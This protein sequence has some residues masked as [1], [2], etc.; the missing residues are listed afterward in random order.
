MFDT[1][2][3]SDCGFGHEIITYLY[4]E[5]GSAERK[6]FEDHLDTCVH[7]PGELAAFASVSTAIG[8]WKSGKFD[9]LSTPQFV[10]PKDATEK[11]SR[12]GLVASPS[13]SEKL[14]ALILNLPGMF[15]TAS[16]FAAIALA[17]GLAWVVFG[18]LLTPDEIAVVPP[19][20][21]KSTSTAAETPVVVR[22]EPADVEAI[23]ENSENSNVPLPVTN[24]QN[25][26]KET[27]NR[28]RKSSVV[29][30]NDRLG[31]PKDPAKSTSKDQAPDKLQ[32]ES[33]P[34]IQRLTELAE[35]DEEGDNEDAGL[36]LSDLFAG[37]D[38]R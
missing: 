27:V 24:P 19:V 5:M 38:E 30:E 8:D 1:R 10:L 33:L 23:E 21:E 29:R 18:G 14:Q 15:K 22:S 35:I 9:P 26:R 37:T 13:V 16:A 11:A 25:S 31:P 34:A 3:H 12:V 7:C 2:N 17:A 28:S 20:E 4:R 32:P 36:R 6:A